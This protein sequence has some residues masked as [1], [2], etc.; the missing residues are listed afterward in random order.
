MELAVLEVLKNTEDVVLVCYSVVPLNQTEIKTCTSLRSFSVLY[1]RGVEFD[2][3]NLTQGLTT[4]PWS[5]AEHIVFREN[6]V[7]PDS[8][9]GVTKGIKYDIDTS[10]HCLRCESVCFAFE[11]EI[12]PSVTCHQFKGIDGTMCTTKGQGQQTYERL[13]E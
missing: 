4:F 9:Q 11:K 10:I 12:I 6:P 1:V 8:M 7:W 5:F 3:S 2:V 13:T